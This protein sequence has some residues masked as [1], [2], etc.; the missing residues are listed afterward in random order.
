MEARVAA[1]GQNS[2][3]AVGAYYMYA[4]ML[5]R[6]DRDAEAEIYARLAVDT[7]T[8]HVDRKHP[9]YARALEALGLLLSRTGR[10]NESLAYLE[11]SIAIKRETS[12]TKSLAFD[13]ALQNLG[14]LLLPLERYDEAEPLFLEAERGFRDIEGDPT[15]S[16]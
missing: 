9:N 1:S 2:A 14:N 7:A 13:F 8:D 6:A 5:S 11:R 15:F 16:K 3:D 12:G 4:Q 10:R